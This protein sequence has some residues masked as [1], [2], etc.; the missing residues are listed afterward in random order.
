LRLKANRA[1]LADWAGVNAVEPSRFRKWLQ[2]I[3]QTRA[4]EISCSMCLDQVSQFVD[5]EVADEPAAE[6]MPA[7][8]QHLGQCRV[9]HEEYVVLREL[10]ELEASG[11][12]PGEDELRR[13]LGDDLR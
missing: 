6:R 13:S 9:C 10:A 7:L 3:V 11:Q 12:L 8:A 4:D 2:Q 1:A 5:L